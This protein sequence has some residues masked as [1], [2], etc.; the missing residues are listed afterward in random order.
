MCD[1]LHKMIFCALLGVVY[2]S[3]FVLAS[4]TW[5]CNLVNRV[6]KFFVVPLLLN[7]IIFWCCFISTITETKEF[8]FVA[9][10]IVFFYIV[11]TNVVE[12]NN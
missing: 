3:M 5:D 12:H 10:A 1:L 4:L 2:N 6:L 7:G 11:R 9:V 8:G